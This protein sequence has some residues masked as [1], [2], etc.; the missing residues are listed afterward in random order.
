MLAKLN[1]EEQGD[2]QA[3]AEQIEEMPEEVKQNEEE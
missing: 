2:E 3:T 1:E